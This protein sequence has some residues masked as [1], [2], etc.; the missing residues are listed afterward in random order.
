VEALG[1]RP[2]VRRIPITEAGCAAG[3]LA[4]GLGGSLCAAE[5]VS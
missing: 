1:L 4:L 3:A 2:D 5:A